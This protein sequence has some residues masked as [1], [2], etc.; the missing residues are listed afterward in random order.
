MQI[1]LREI[2]QSLYESS[3]INL[4]KIV[5]ASSLA[6]CGASLTS[7]IYVVK[8]GDDAIIENKITGEKNLVEKDGLYFH[9]PFIETHVIIKDLLT[10]PIV[11]HYI[12]L[13][14]K[15]LGNYIQ[16]INPILDE[17]DWKEIMNIYKT[18]DMN[19]LK[20]MI[21]EDIF[22][23]QN[24]GVI[25]ERLHKAIELYKDNIVNSVIENKSILNA[26]NKNFHSIN[27]KAI[28]PEKYFAAPTG[29][30]AIAAYDNINLSV[31][32]S[33]EVLLLSLTS[34]VGNSMKE[35]ITLAETLIRNALIHE[36][37]HANGIYDERD[38]QILTLKVLEDASLT[39]ENLKLNIGLHIDEGLIGLLYSLERSIDTP[40][41]KYIAEKQ[42]SYNVEFIKQI[43]IAS[44]TDNKI[45]IKENGKRIE[46]EN[47]YFPNLSSFVKK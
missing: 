38:T 24:F 23:L 26:L 45:Y 16:K 8:N 40:L 2:K 41:G 30:Y 13:Y 3:H 18:N 32:I 1:K 37:I 12:K 36:I 11:E 6:V 4:S 43:M 22:I 34:Y 5:L 31:N 44:L 27:G 39:D 33:A 29:G 10:Q 19:E 14:Q 17:D 42:N 35:D 15:E 7:S 46:F 25:T 47:N 20:Y 9:L 21:G 28:I